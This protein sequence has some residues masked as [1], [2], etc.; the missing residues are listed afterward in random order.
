MQ[1]SYGFNEPGPLL[2]EQDVAAFEKEIGTSLPDD[3][4]VLLL[5]NNGGY[6]ENDCFEYGDDFSFVL[7]ELYS[8]ADILSRYEDRADP[9]SDSRDIP[10]ELL[11]IG[12]SLCGDDLCLG[13]RAPHRDKVFWINHEYRDPDEAEENP[14][15]AIEELSPSFA[16]FMTS[17]TSSW[18][19]MGLP[20]PFK[21]P[22]E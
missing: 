20:S 22:T 11:V 15:L 10:Q 4:R 2:T 6:P 3:F 8:L 16:H 21:E 18:A 1:L 14:W 19:S 13:L 12:C 9:R 7:Q 5:A 17:L